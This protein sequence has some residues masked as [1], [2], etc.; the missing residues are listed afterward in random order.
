MG[1]LEDVLS[2]SL[3]LTS[4]T[5]MTCS[6]VLADPSLDD[7]PLVGCSDGFEALSGYSRWDVVG[8]NCRFLNDSVPME[9]QMR[10]AL[11]SA[12]A[13]GTEF[14]GILPNVRKS[15]ER[16]RNFLH[17]IPVAI[18]GRSYIIGIQCDVTHMGL[19]LTDACHLNDLRTVAQ[20]ILA[21][22]IAAWVQVQ[23]R[24][25][26]ARFPVLRDEMISK[27]VTGDH[28]E[29]R[30]SIVEM[31]EP[32]VQT[33]NTFL[34]VVDSKNDNYAGV[35]L[36][37][38]ASDS[39]L[40]DFSTCC[41]SVEEVQSVDTFNEDSSWQL[42]Q[43]G[44]CQ[45][46]DSLGTSGADISDDSK[47]D[48]EKTAWKS[49]GSV[50]HPDRCTECVFFFFRSQGCRK[51]SDCE[52]CHEFHPRKNLKKNRRHV[53][54]LAGQGVA[55]PTEDAAGTS[56][57][58]AGSQ[59][60]ALKSLGSVGHPEK[61][62]ECVFF[63]FRSQGCE[64]GSQCQFCHELHPR[65]N[66][67][68]N[69]QFMRRLTAQGVAVSKDNAAANLSGEPWHPSTFK[70]GNQDEDGSLSQ[71]SHPSTFQ[72]GNQ[73]ED[74]CLS[75][76]SHP[77]TFQS[78]NQDED[79]SL[80]Q[81]EPTQDG[82]SAT[83]A[84]PP[85]SRATVELECNLPVASI[86]YLRLGSEKQHA[87]LT[88]CV[89]QPVHLPAYVDM[90]SSALQAVQNMMTFSVTPSLQQGLNLHPQTGLISGV[91]MKVDEHKI[92]TVIVSIVATGPG[93]VNLGMVPLASTSVLIRVL[94]YE[95]CKASDRHY[96]RMT[97]KEMRSS[98]YSRGIN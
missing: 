2:E 97:D 26:K 30:A 17:M 85:C 21:A 3:A 33:K 22:N 89:G 67:R 90:G 94:H 32:I 71:W 95:R 51:G 80:S 36:R 47:E 18:G 20:H 15:G 70:S 12:T 7:C 27:L 56:D 54:R 75:Q 5:R 28:E 40:L 62:I 49:I 59:R 81:W 52:F 55:V 96:M 58:D 91:A 38:S 39:L 72:S 1:S 11:H 43:S 74:G 29:A 86:R 83:S 57:D 13:T 79:G 48:R 9:M 88:F 78:G 76:W 93:G 42:S 16:F 60:T 50:G 82:R 87:K 10:R 77:S 8:R 4:V 69:R 73:D 35:G 65:K 68:K 6:V 46:D 44:S 98:Q 53:R 41:S 24:I 45:Q 92:H 63:F 84:E 14:I 19:D 34:H 23:V 31:T 37:K 64:K 61:C 25:F 66:L